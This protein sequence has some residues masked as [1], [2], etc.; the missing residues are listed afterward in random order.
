MDSKL[1]QLIKIDQLLALKYGTK[2]FT[3]GVDP[4]T[5]LVRTILSQNTNDINRDRAFMELMGTFPK[6]A[7]IAG[8]P[9]SKVAA[10]IKVAGLAK[11][12]AGRIIK[13]L[14]AINKSQ[15]EYELAFLF[16][17]QDDQVKQYLLGLDGVGPKTAACVMAFSL[18]RNVM[19]VDTH[20]YRVSRRL[21]FLPEKI[22]VEMAHN[23]FTQFGNSISLYQL[24]LNLIAHG[25]QI[26]HARKPLCYEC[27][28]KRLC[29]FY[30]KSA[31]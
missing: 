23:Y 19:P 3:A 18:G 7:D 21:G 15:G 20:V 17:W 13:L 12:R 24:H 31:L 8:A 2:K 9:I 30:R 14:K 25:R 22:S 5:E 10:T 28:L 1:K 29:H 4:L 6:W 16:D 27:R 26:C 11:I